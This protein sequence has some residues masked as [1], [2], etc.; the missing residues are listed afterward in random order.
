MNEPVVTPETEITQD[1]VISYEEID[2]TPISDK[3][4]RRT[5]A[6]HMAHDLNEFFAEQGIKTAPI[7]AE[8]I[9]CVNAA[10]IRRKQKQAKKKNRKRK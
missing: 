3:L 10:E 9:S 1:V 8:E 5:S 7:S 4:L 6:A 2:Q